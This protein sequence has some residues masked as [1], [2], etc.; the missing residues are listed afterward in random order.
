[1]QDIDRELARDVAYALKQSPFKAKGQP[2]E[3][4]ALISTGVVGHLRRCGWRFEL[5]PPVAP[6]GPAF[7]PAGGPETRG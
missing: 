1:M 5:G 3:T 4:L 6:H 2:I 7:D